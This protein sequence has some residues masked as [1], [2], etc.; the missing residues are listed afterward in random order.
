MRMI[1]AFGQ[2]CLSWKWPPWILFLFLYGWNIK[3]EL[4]TYSNH[5]Q[6]SINNWDL[7][8]ELFSNPFLAVYL[9]LPFVL[10]WSCKV[11]LLHGG[12][13][14]LIRLRSYTKWLL[15]LTSKILPS[16]IVLLI[17]WILISFILTLGIPFQLFWSPYSFEDYQINFITTSLQQYVKYPFLAL[18]I[19][20]LQYIW[21]FITLHIVIATFYLYRQKNSTL[22]ILS[23]GLFLG[24]VLS[25]KIFSWNWMNIINYYFTYSSL[26]NLHSIFTPFVI[27]TSII[28]A[29]LVFTHYFTSRNGDNS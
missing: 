26:K 29:C 1:K 14:T 19:Q 23:A 16:L 2:E 8:F 22:V 10:L 17:S 6:I 27:L 9:I 24:T 11:I 20:T 7:V 3:S 12:Y 13:I 18:L 21:F 28:L 25:F 5:L 15:F 4:I